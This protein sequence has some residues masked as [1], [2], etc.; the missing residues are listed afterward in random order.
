VPGKAELLDLMLDAISAPDPSVASL[1]DDWRT[2]MEALG[3]GMWRLYLRTRG[4]RSWSRA[5]RCSGRPPSTDSS[6]PCTAWT[7]Q[8]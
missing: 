6:S 1:G 2:A 4:C 8:A 3:R 5:G 7:I